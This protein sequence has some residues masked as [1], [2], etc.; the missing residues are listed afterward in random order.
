MLKEA[1]EMGK[2][3]L[4]VLGFAYREIPEKVALEDDGRG[5]YER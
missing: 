3:A 2:D 1:E 5:W 4:R